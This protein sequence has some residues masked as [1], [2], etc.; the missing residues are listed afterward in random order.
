MP[1]VRLQAKIFV[2]LSPV[3][4]SLCISQS[5]SSPFKSLSLSLSVS[6]S[7]VIVQRDGSESQKSSKRFISFVR[8]ESVL[9]A[10][11]RMHHFLIVVARLRL[12]LRLLLSSPSSYF[13][14]DLSI[15][16]KKIQD[17]FRI[18]TTVIGSSGSS[19]Q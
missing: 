2:T 4:V 18:S 14:D 7:L 5:L 6:L 12:R 1:A 8:N 15:V 3:A 9:E 10:Q 16:R 17:R 19:W 13:R 11:Y